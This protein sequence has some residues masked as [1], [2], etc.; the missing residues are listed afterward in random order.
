LRSHDQLLLNT[1]GAPDPMSFLA[2]DYLAHVHNL[3][4]NRQIDWKISQQISKGE[5]RGT[6][7]IS[8]ILMFYWFE[9]FLYL[10]PVFEFPEITGKPG[11]FVGI[12]DNVG[13]ALTFKILKNDLNKVYIE[14]LF[15]MLYQ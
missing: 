4:T 3:G 11:Y 15:D 5:G 9:N 12:A 2:Q 6:I 10:D 14:V 13:D 8:H 1:T 7:G